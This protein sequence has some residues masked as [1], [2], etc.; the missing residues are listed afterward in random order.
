MLELKDY[1]FMKEKQITQQILEKTSL[2]KKFNYSESSYNKAVLEEAIKFLKIK[3][4][5]TH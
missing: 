5:N 1:E 2:M 4:M 3:S